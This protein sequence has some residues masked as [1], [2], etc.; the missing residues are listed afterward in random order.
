MAD[1]VGVREQR[2]LDLVATGDP[3]ASLV[4]ELG[5]WS[6]SSHSNH[7]GTWQTREFVWPATPAALVAIKGLGLEG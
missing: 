5:T 3:L 1:L 7:D 4:S 6:V 2:L